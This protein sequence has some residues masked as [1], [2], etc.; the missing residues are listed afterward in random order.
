M[1]KIKSLFINF[2]LSSISI[3]IPLLFFSSYQYLEYAKQVKIENNEKILALN[4]G[5]LPTFYPQLII[6]QMKKMKNAKIYPVGALPNTRTY[7]TNEGYGLISYTSDRF[8]FRNSDTKW[9]N[10]SNQKNI[11][12]IGDSFVH[13]FSVSDE[14]TIPSNIEKT[15]K[16][17]TFNLGMGGNNPYEYIAVLKTL[18]SP[19]IK[20][21]KKTNKVA[22]VFYAGDKSPIDRKKKKL[23]N[24][25]QKIVISSKYKGAL[26]TEYYTENIT[27]FIKNNYPEPAQEIISKI[28]NNSHIK[29]SS[30]Y[31]ITTL[32]P[33]R[34]K[35]GLA[36][37]RSFFITPRK[38]SVKLSETPSGKSISLLSEV[39]KNP[40]KPIIVYIPNSKIWHPISS[41]Q[42]YKRELKE[43]SKRVGISFLDCEEIIDSNAPDDYSPKGPHLSI[44]G[45]KKVADLISREIMN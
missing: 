12:V 33:I 37:L 38:P 20:N 8:G 3:Y 21:S 41:S 22:L 15:T 36:S 30:F 11:F 10:I 28:K 39:C 14:A 29:K 5:Y 26:P 32:F 43:M 7:L 13:G 2:L 44:E 6:R 18:V 40:C 17:N 34:S 1:K 42:T 23:L 27:S 35:I 4:A 19:L 24:S 31:Y 16:I 45:Y 25:T 9:E